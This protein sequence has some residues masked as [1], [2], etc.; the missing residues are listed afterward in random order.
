MNMSITLFKQ[1]KN[2]TNTVIYE[3]AISQD[4]MLKNKIRDEFIGIQLGH[5]ELVLSENNV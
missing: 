4:K 5:L 2:R 1:V 3:N